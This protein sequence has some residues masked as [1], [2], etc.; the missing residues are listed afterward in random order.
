MV[1][2]TLENMADAAQ[3][4]SRD[5][6]KAWIMDALATARRTIRTI[7]MIV[8]RIAAR[9]PRAAQQIVR[10]SDPFGEIPSDQ[11]QQYGAP[12]PQQEG[13]TLD[14]FERSATRK[15]GNTSNAPGAGDNE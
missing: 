9:D 10:A 6:S 1:T 14:P 2:G 11:M 12:E 15:C 3:I 8:Q 7:A 4:A 5:A 13:H